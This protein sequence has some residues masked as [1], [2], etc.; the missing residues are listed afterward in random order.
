VLITADGRATCGKPHGSW[1]DAYSDAAMA[2]SRSPVPWAYLPG[3]F[4]SASTTPLPTV[5]RMPPRC[6]CRFSVSGCRR[7]TPQTAGVRLRPPATAVAR[8]CDVHHIVWCGAVANGGGEC[9]RASTPQA[10]WACRGSPARFGPTGQGNSRCRESRIIDGMS[11]P[12]RRSTQKVRQARS[13]QTQHNALNTAGSAQRP[14]QRSPTEIRDRLKRAR[15]A[16]DAAEA[17]LD[18]IVDRAVDLGIGWPEI[19]AQLGVTRQAARQRYQRRHGT[20]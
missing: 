14:S 8:E 11:K 5:R 3:T 19:A 15:S 2:C 17:E 12:R 9:S 6:K 10:R 18:A 20:D 16:R 4:G 1:P 13:S 7:R